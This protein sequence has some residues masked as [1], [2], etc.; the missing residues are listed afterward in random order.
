MSIEKAT[1]QDRTAI[2]SLLEAE[3]LPA[4][5]L[6]AVLDNFLIIRAENRLAGVIGLERYGV[7]GLLRS[8]VVHPH[9]RNRQ[10]AANLVQ[11]LEEEAIAAGITTLFLLTETAENYFR[12]KG[13]QVTARSAVPEVLLQSSEFS[14]V[15]PASATVMKKALVPV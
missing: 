6:P 15:C 12:K 2:V 13:Y 9:Y 1:Q 8:M 3:K 5:D 14:H 7:Y 4:K 11:A 10:L